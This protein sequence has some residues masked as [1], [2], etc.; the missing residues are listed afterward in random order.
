[1][2]SLLFVPA[3]DA[4]KLAKGLECG[5]DALIVDL[6]DAVPDAEKPRAREMCAEFVAAHRAR[7]PIF[8]RVNALSTGLTNADL[9]AVVGARP[10]GI[11]LP[12]CESGHDVAMLDGAISEFESRHG[13]TTGSLRILPLVTETAAS[14]FGMHSY[15]REAG[16]RLCGMFWGGE[17][18]ASDIG[19]S[20]NRDPAG[21]YTAPYEMAR[22]LTLIGAAA[23][24]VPAI[25]AVYTN[26]RDREG[27]RAEAAEAMRDGFSAK[28]AIHP[29]Q[30]AVI[31]A[32]FT[33]S[34]GE[35][36]SARAVIAAF[37]AAP[38]SGAIAIN[39]KMLDRPHY[40]AAQR[41]LA[42]AASNS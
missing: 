3:H 20:A 7:M 15:A 38:A 17:D 32:V 10:F 40:R 9:S 26:F 13:V 35:V 21:R 18:L 41:L 6:E 19:A 1:M 4:R 30:I 23:A 34:Q 5:A 2:R 28:V 25:D 22:A 37:D 31:H 39:G 14:L 16:P 24:Q 42:R 8:V 33:P 11:M 12:K 29:D 27:L 36:D